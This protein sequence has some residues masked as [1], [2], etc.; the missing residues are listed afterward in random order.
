MGLNYCQQKHDQ[1][2]YC[3]FGHKVIAEVILLKFFG[4]RH[5]YVKVKVREGVTDEM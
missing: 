2:T 5:I 4:Q 1:E 3:G